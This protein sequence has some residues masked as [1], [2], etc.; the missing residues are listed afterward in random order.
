MGSRE[1]G[2]GTALPPDQ[3]LFLTPAPQHFLFLLTLQ[4]W[5]S[6]LPWP[7]KQPRCWI[8]AVSPLCILCF[9]RGLSVGRRRGAWLPGCDQLWTG[10][11]G[12]R[13]EGCVTT[14]SWALASPAAPSSP[15]A[16]TA[17]H[18]CR[19]FPLAV[20][21]PA[22]PVSRSP[23]PHL[24]SLTTHSFMYHTSPWL[25]GASGCGSERQVLS[26]LG[27]PNGWGVLSQE[28]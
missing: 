14:A 9:R 4:P 26:N 19:L 1:A 25:A 28:A 11:A 27:P 5:A 20:R 8:P 24:P 2:R 7:R 16:M 17:P 21:I 6:D 15:R 3:P 18:P 13:G 22:T 10:L 23:I 12:R